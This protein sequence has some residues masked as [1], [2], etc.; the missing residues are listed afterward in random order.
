MTRH[1]DIILILA[2]LAII[3]GMVLLRHGCTERADAGIV[4]QYPP[5]WAINRT[6]A[7]PVLPTWHQI[8]DTPGARNRSGLAVLGNYMYL[9]GGNDGVT[10]GKTNVYRCDGTGWVEVAG[11]PAV[12]ESGG[13][14]TYSNRIIYSSGDLNNTRYTNCYAYNGTSWTEVVGVPLALK[15][16]AA[17]VLGDYYYHVGAVS[18]VTA[19]NVLKYDNSTWTQVAGTPY[20]R[21]WAS[22]AVLGDK[23]YSIGGDSKTNTYA[24]D[25]A[26][27][28]QVAGTPGSVHAGGACVFTNR[29]YLHAGGPGTNIYLFDGT[30]WTKGVGIPSARYLD[31]MCTFSGRV[32]VVGG[33]GAVG[34]SNTVWWWDGAN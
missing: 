30:N 12:S 19:T 26:S 1:T 7:P 32:Y 33:Y 34:V 31:S 13:V 16:G 11:L 2:G 28:T 6:S 24:F 29:I 27:W 21:D 17:G 25:G 20:A 10:G 15:D 14:A 5:V 8:A 18:T 9:C 4:Q 23:L 3:C 22:L